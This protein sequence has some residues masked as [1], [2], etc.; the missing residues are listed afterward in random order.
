MFD[1]LQPCHYRDDISIISSR[2]AP[3][4]EAWH[5]STLQWG[6]RPPKTDFPFEGGPPPSH[7]PDLDNDSNANLHSPVFPMQGQVRKIHV[8][9]PYY[10]Y[11]LMQTC[12]ICYRLEW[13]LEVLSSFRCASMS[14]ESTV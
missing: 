4:H 12:L 14:Y 1:Q 7:Y 13:F 9:Q 8:T 3:M 10:R 5:V 11:Y 6:P 2:A